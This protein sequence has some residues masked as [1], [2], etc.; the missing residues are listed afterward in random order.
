[1]TAAS[2]SPAAPRNP[3]DRPTLLLV[4]DEER[5]LRSLRMLFAVQYRVLMT[6]DGREALD[7]LRRERVH[8]LVSDQRMPIMPGVELLRQAREIS[9]TT[10]RLLLT[11]YS[12]LEAIIGSINEG[13]IFRYINKPWQTD[14]IRRIVGEAAEIA[15]QLEQTE[16]PLSAP[17]EQGERHD[18]MVVDQAPETATAIRGVL[19]EQFASGHRLEWATSVNEALSLLEKQDFSVVISEI[20]VNGEDVSDFLKALKR[21]HPQI[22]TIVLTAHSDATQ[23]M[24]LINQGQIHR[25][26]PKPV[27]KTVMARGIQ[28]GIDR[29]RQ[30][31]NQPTLAQ[32]HRVE[33]PKTAAN[34]T[35]IHR[36]RNIF[37]RLSA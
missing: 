9:P 35:L 16:L 28:S 26:L 3:G 36:L 8:V 37:G 2:P 30:I 12:D 23:L 32:C 34:P 11:G 6:T 31:R 1:M 15:R 27:R 20:R 21:Y 17:A 5:I 13:E 29:H 10:L 19:D 18:I 33:A 4:D 22:A 7:I 25:F 24:E 14:E